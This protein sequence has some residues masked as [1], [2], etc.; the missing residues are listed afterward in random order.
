MSEAM[1]AAVASIIESMGTDPAKAA[2]VIVAMFSSHIKAAEERGHARAI[3]VQREDWSTR[4][5]DQRE[6]QRRSRAQNMSQDV[7]GQ[8]IDTLSSS[9]LKQEV[10]SEC[11]KT[12]QDITRH[13][14]DFWEMYPRKEGKADARRAW[15]KAAPT[16]GGETAL[17]GLV[18]KALEWQRKSR[19]WTDK[20]GAFIPHPSTYLNRGSWDDEPYTTAKPASKTAVDRPV[21]MPQLFDKPAAWR[22]SFESQVTEREQIRA[23][24]EMASAAKAAT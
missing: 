3:L 20:H 16:V 24:A 1:A 2:K 23:V 4:K 22:P 21:V 18:T 15:K 7:P 9:S 17:F 19:S 13:F 11:L 8:K 5:K 10:S 12:S 6:A 14:A